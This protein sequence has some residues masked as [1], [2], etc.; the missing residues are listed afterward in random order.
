MKKDLINAIEKAMAQEGLCRTEERLAD[1]IYD[2]GIN[3]D[4]LSIILSK[5]DEVLFST[6]SGQ[7]KRQ[8]NIPECRSMADFLPTLT[9]TA[10]SLAMELTRHNVLKKD[11]SGEEKI[12]EEHIDNNTAVRK[13]LLDRGIN[14]ETLPPAEDIAQVKKRISRED[15]N[16]LEIKE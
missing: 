16:T 14:P 10:K 5:G 15:K 3:E 2:R 6:S 4:S 12:T 8:L 7:I 11:L 9:I 13:I 1:I